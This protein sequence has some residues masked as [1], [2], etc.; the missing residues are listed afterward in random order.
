[1]R[2]HAQVARR[3]M[4]ALTLVVVLPE[5]SYADAAA[6]MRARFVNKEDGLEEVSKSKGARNTR[7]A[8]RLYSAKQQFVDLFK[9]QTK[10][11]LGSCFVGDE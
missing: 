2:A 7:A 9:R 11:I 5:E 8:E 10:A 1:M 4:D 6:A 3:I